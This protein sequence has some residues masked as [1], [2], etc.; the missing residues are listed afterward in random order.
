MSRLYFVFPSGD[1]AVEI[2]PAASRLNLNG[3]NEDDLFRLL[4]ALGAEPAQAKDIAMAIID[5]RSPS[6][7]P[8]FFDRHYLSMTPSFRARHTS[9]EEVEEVLL[10]RG[11]TPELFY[12]SYVRDPEG[13]LVRR[14]G[15]RDCVSPYGATSTFDVNTADPALLVSIGI[16]PAAV[17]QLVARRRMMP[18]RS[19]A[20]LEPFRQFAGP[21]A[22]RLGIGGVSIYTLR[23]TARHRLENG[24]L[25]EGRRSVAATVKYFGPLVTPP[26][27]ILRWHDSAAADST[28]WWPQ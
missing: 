8:S 20:E 24:Q 21:A 16:N 13:R 6:Q 12:G 10:V 14:S 22:H 27:Q 3:A 2:I 15:L 28:E 11:M 26:F 4:L 9:F 18:F 17:Q 25:A 23:A 5:W 19:M 7:G 1:A